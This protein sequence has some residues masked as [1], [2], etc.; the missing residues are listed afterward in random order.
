MRERRETVSN[1]GVERGG[2][3][4]QGEGE[5]ERERERE[6]HCSDFNQLSLAL[7]AL[8]SARVLLNHVLHRERKR[9]SHLLMYHE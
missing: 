8:S 5:R 3:E 4:G 9:E 6:T 1:R 2:M 7:P